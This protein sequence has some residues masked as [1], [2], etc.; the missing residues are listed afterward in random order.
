MNGLLV[1]KLIYQVLSNDD[2][3]DSKVGNAIF[4]LVAPQDTAF[5][6]IVYTKSNV[7][8]DIHSKD[9]WLSDAINFTITIVSDNYFTGVNIA[10]QVRLLFENRI[11]S[12]DELKINNIHLVS[13]NESFNEDT[14][15]QNLYFSCEADE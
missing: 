2:Y 13:S 11:I 15:I 7:F 4:P 1:G 9:G 3:I 5:P 10:N 12:N 8:T 14:Y 6:F